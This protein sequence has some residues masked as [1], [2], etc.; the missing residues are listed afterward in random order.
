MLLVS[1]CMRQSRSWR[2][3]WSAVADSLPAADRLQSQLNSYR[4]E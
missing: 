4:I 2:K 1:A 3:L